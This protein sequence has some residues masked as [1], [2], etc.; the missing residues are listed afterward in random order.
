LPVRNVKREEQTN[1][2][3]HYVD[4]SAV[5]NTNFRILSSKTVKGKDAP[6]RARRPI[7]AGDV[8]FSNV[9]TYL[10]NVA[11]VPKD[12]AFDLCSTGFTVLRPSAA[13][14]PDFLFRYVLSDDF[15]ERVSPTQTGTHY[16]ATSDVAVMRETIE[17]PPLAEQKRIVAKLEDLLLRIIAAR[18]RLAR[19]PIILKRF[20]QSALAAACS[21]RLTEDWRDSNS[22]AGSASEIVEGLK[23]LHEKAGTARRGNAAAPSEEAHDLDEAALPISW[24]V[25]ELKWLCDP[26]RP[27]T[28]GILK[29]GPD[30]SD[31]VPYV[32]VA[33]FPGNRLGLSGIRRTTT[34][35]SEA[36][37]RSRLREGDVLLSIRGTFGR[38]CRVP[39][40]LNSA[41]ITQD[42]ARLSIARSVDA[43][44]VFLYLLSPEVQERLGRAARG[45]AVRGVNIGDVRA[46]QVA[47]PPL[48]EQQEIA[49][50]VDRLFQLADAIGKRVD[51]ATARVA[52][53]TRAV[54]AK[55][56]RGELVPTEAELARR[57]GRDYEPAADL[58]ER[59]RTVVPAR[60]PADGPG[61]PQS[62]RG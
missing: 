24:A 34:A 35:I 13:I 16:P 18:E 36:Y 6:S 37:R 22:D 14:E 20:R 44:Y 38:V 47:L 30:Q 61:R 23:T 49:R 55:A 11:L 26:K 31:G 46:L 3:F 15:I 17:L 25:A 33:D 8:L 51:V 52:K 40:E 29:P 7:R 21:G 54:L 5:D 10:R 9:R 48:P 4:I 53:L 28:Y 39:P 19:V 60:E 42:T 43:N 2:E 1:R 45:V 32:R 57:E 50:R 59:L 27:I 56:F 12:S 62:K 41:N 58:L